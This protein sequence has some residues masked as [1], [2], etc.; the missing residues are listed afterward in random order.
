[1]DGIQIKKRTITNVKYKIVYSMKNNMQ[2]HLPAGDGAFYLIHAFGANNN[3]L[4][5][6]Y[7]FKCKN[8]LLY[9]I[10]VSLFVQ[11]V[12]KA[13]TAGLAKCIEYGEV[14]YM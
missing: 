6:K 13:S 2:P 14:P 5:R 10:T 11:T 8:S 3:Q 7:L 12:Y 1:M 4:F 9:G